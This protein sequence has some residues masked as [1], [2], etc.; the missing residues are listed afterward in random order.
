MKNN[1]TKEDLQTGHI[2]VTKNEGNAIV[3]GKFLKRSGYLMEDE[4]NMADMDSY[5]SDLKTTPLEEY[6]IEK[7]YK[8]VDG[9]ESLKTIIDELPTDSVEL[10]WKREKEIDWNKVPKFTRVQVKDCNEEEWTNM[11][12]IGIR[13]TKYYPYTTSYCS[14]FSYGKGQDARLRES[15]WEQIRIYDES[16]IQEDW[17]K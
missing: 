14:E 6:S 4:V 8:I 1:F 9:K 13:D 10:I 2:V 12:F 17:Y 15:C 3:I 16:E 11:Y 5:T 7:V